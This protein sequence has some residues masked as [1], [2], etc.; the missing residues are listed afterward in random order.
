MDDK[1]LFNEEDFEYYFLRM[2]NRGYP[3]LSNQKDIAIT[4]KKATKYEQY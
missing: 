1:N 4:G 3:T 2:Y